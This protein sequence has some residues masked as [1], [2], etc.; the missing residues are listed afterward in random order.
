MSIPS[1]WRQAAR[2]TCVHCYGLPL[3]VVWEGVKR[4]QRIG[5]LPVTATDGSSATS[6]LPAVS[7][8]SAAPTTAATPEQ[9]A[10]IGGYVRWRN[11]RAR[12]KTTQDPASPP[13]HRPAPGPIT[14]PAKYVK[15]IRIWGFEGPNLVRIRRFVSLNLAGR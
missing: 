4:L 9:N 6:F 11:A 1:Y 2:P 5:I 12:P 14:Y 13:T 10:A 8:P 3:P 7:S 15:F